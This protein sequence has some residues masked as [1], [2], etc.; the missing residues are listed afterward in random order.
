M[1]TRAE[2]LSGGAAELLSG[3]GGVGGVWR[4]VLSVL[5]MSGPA[6]RTAHRAVES[7]RSSRL[8]MPFL[9]IQGNQRSPLPSSPRSTVSLCTWKTNASGECQRNA[10]VITEPFMRGT[11][12]SWLRALGSAPMALTVSPSLSQV[13]HFA[14]EVA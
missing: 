9:C 7:D 10:G 13:M 12:P 3:S 5:P 8:G 1:T 6:H 4:I 14:S 2:L 11:A